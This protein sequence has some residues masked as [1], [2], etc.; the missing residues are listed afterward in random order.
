VSYYI[1]NLF[2]AD[3][4]PKPFSKKPRMTVYRNELYD[5]AECINLGTLLHGRFKELD[6]L[7]AGVVNDILTRWQKADGSFRARKLLAGWDNVP[8]HRW[9]QSQMFRSLGFFLARRLN[10][11]EKPAAVAEL[12]PVV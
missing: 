11:T 4:L 9:A 5:C 10:V 12:R 2:D 8:M 6:D 3:G 1:R 7:V